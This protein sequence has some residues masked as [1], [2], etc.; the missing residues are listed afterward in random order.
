MKMGET[1]IL[2]LPTELL[3]LIC[4]F[5]AHEDVLPFALT[6][7]VLHKSALDELRIRQKVFQQYQVINDDDPLIL[8]N[9]L[10]TILANPFNA[11][12]VRH[13]CFSCVRCQW[14]EWEIPLPGEWLPY[15]YSEERDKWMSFYTHDELEKY[16]RLLRMYIFNGFSGNTLTNAHISALRSGEDDVLKVLLVALCPRLQSVTLAEHPG[17]QQGPRARPWPLATTLLSA[18]QAAHRT[19]YNDSVRRA[20]ASPSA[21]LEKWPPGFRNLRSISL[22]APL[23]DGRTGEPYHVRPANA[24]ALFFLPRIENLELRHLR[25]RYDG[26]EST[27]VEPGCSNVKTLLFDHCEIRQTTMLRFLSAARNLETVSISTSGDLPDQMES[28][29]RTWYP[30]SFVSYTAWNGHIRVT[31]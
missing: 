31:S 9:R 29:L 22:C 24:S 5:L 19:Y 4:S 8:L 6:S 28:W 3:A 21:Q 7:H 17:Y 13:L 25:H 14:R 26:F 2:M 10:R 12:C 20:I 11:S 1:G 23:G 18:S 16:R 30:T 15:T 27:H